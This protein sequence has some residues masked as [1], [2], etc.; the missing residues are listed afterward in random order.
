VGGVPGS[1]AHG[2]VEATP[3]PGGLVLAA[4][5]TAAVAAWQLR[6]S[7]RRLAGSDSD[8]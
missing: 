6:Q 1:T 4:L 5:G 3:E 7:R 8:A 2:K